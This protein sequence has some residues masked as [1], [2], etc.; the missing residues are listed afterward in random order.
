M[1]RPST[2]TVVRHRTPPSRRFMTTLTHQA[3]TLSD[4]RQLGFAEYGKS[5]GHPIFYFHGFPSSRLEAQ[6]IDEI[7]QRVGV[8]LIALDRPGFGLSTPNPD[9][10]IVDW[11]SDVMELAE[12]KGIDRFSVCGL[13]GGGPFALA[14]AYALPKSK[15]ASVGLFASAPH[16]EAGIQHVD[17]SRRLLRFFAVNYPNLLGGGLNA[18]YRSIRWLILTRP[19]IKRIGKWLDAEDSKHPPTEESKK[20]HAE[21]IQDL[22][23]IFLDETFRQG[24]G[25]AVHEVRLLSSLDWGFKL[26]D[27]TFGKVLMW[28]GVEDTNAT[29]EMIRYMEEKVPGSELMEFEGET[30]YTMW[31]HVEAALKRLVDE[32]GL[33]DSD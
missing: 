28:H 6:P 3:H 16:W 18:L 5:N 19:A 9:Y 22:V 29:I 25:G 20:P 8:R 26:E 27:V 1:L 17:L 33:E 10:R 2:Q 24:A 7:A 23:N 12:A 21:R 30:H 14:C 32:G 11:P 4:G 31:K 15:L 13:S